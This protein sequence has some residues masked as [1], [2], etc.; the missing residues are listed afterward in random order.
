VNQWVYGTV[1]KSYCAFCVKKS[2]ETEGE[3][4]LMV[5]MGAGKETETGN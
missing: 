4:E 3:D 5:G 1:Q 2:G